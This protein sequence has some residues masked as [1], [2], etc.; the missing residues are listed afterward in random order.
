LKPERS[1]VVHQGRL[2]VQLREAELAQVLAQIAQQAGIAIVGSPGL[3]HRVSAQ[4]IDIDLA[5]GLRRLVQQASFGSAMRYAS[6]P[7]GD[8][9][10]T[11]VHVFS[12]ARG[13]APGQQTVA[14]PEGEERPESVSQPFVA[15]LAQISRR[16]SSATDMGESDTVR[17]VRDLL[18]STP[19]GT[20]P[21]SAEEES[22][23]AQHF[24]AALQ[25]AHR[26]G[27]DVEV[28]ASPQR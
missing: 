8:V 20:H 9:S 15:A 21:P 2:S 16:W 24:R 19:Q 25:R 10:L 26:P 4:L 22:E 1:I 17:R 27:L 23:L 3:G 7:G 12:A 5:E 28:P 18:E 14:E 11:E 13:E 6:G